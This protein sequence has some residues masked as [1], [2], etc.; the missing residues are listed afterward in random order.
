MLLMSRCGSWSSGELSDCQC[1]VCRK[2]APPGVASWAWSFIC[3]TSA[4]RA[5]ALAAMGAE[6]NLLRHHRHLSTR[7]GRLAD[8][9]GVGLLPT[10]RQKA[11]SPFT[12]QGLGMAHR[13]AASPAR[14]MAATA[15]AASDHMACGRLVERKTLLLL[16]RTCLLHLPEGLVDPRRQVV[17]EKVCADWSGVLS[18]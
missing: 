11:T 13:A 3:P 6:D 18:Q 14:A 17:L 2:D 7:P 15:K 1:A 5:E 12:G 9:H 10:L 8:P 16:A 4:T